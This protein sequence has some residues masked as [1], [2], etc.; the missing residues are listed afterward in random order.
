MAHFLSVGL[1]V[2][3]DSG[4]NHQD[5]R[6]FGKGDRCRFLQMANLP[7]SAVSFALE[8]IS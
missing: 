6:T 3:C 8:A 5:L 2:L 4:E 7:N 1:A